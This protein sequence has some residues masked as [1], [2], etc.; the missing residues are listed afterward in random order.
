MILLQDVGEHTKHSTDLRPEL[1]DPYSQP[2]ELRRE[3]RMR[4][5]QL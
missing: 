2:R 1:A 5:K 4:V 3:E